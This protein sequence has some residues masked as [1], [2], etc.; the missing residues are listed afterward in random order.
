MYLFS[1]KRGELLQTV[2]TAS[3]NRPG[4][5]AVTKHGEL[6]YTDPIAKTLN[7][8]KDEG[9]ESITL[10]NWTPYR[11]RST[12]SG[13]LL[14]NMH[15]N[16]D[17]RLKVVRYSGSTEKQSILLKDRTSIYEHP[18]HNK[19]CIS[20]NRNLDICLVHFNDKS[21]IVINQAGKQRFIYRGQ[22]SS[23]K[24][25]PFN[26]K[27]ITTDSR[28]QILIADYDNDCVHIIDR[29]GTYV[30]RPYRLWAKGP[31]WTLYRFKGQSVCS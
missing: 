28:S 5:I 27:G 13:D 19:N 6:V 9:T 26:P 22:T 21:I 4:G 7:I 23:P 2:G 17:K 3:K 20:E 18:V 24:R 25:K 8:V 30:P 1:I 15:S 16:R 10:Q 12:P 29:D 14:V 31:F 11:V